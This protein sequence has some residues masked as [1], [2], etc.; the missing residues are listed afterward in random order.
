MFRFE[1]LEKTDIDPNGGQSNWQSV[2]VQIGSIVR[3][4][5]LRQR[6]EL[7]CHDKLVLSEASL[8]VFVFRLVALTLTMSRRSL[9]L[10][11]VP[12]NLED[13]LRQFRRDEQ[14]YGG[15][16]RN[17]IILTAFLD[18]RVR[19]LG[20]IV[21]KQVTQHRGALYIAVLVHK[22]F[23]VQTNECFVG[24]FQF[25]SFLILQKKVTRIHCRSVHG[26]RCCDTFP[27][28]RSIEI[29]VLLRRMSRYILLVLL[30]ILFILMHRV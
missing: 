22:Q 7:Q 21:R 23:V 10:R 5:L 3:Q 28:E 25:D 20:C 6:N 15:V 14:L 29:K 19:K 12:N 18:K 11:L 13:M 16:L 30:L 17:E 4:R 8:H 26:S 2:L 1:K 9:L 27:L 24:L